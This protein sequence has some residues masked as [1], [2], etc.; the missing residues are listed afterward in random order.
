MLYE[1][2]ALSVDQFIRFLSMN[3]DLS[4]QQE[5]LSEID[6]ITPLSIQTAAENYLDENKMTIVVIGS[7]AALLPPLS[8][9]GSVEVFGLDEE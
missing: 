5:L 2:V 8:T 4:Y 9:L 6:R 7:K 1:N 3:V